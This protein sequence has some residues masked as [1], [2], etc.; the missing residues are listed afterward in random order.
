MKITL[1][2]ILFFFKFFVFFLFDLPPG[3]KL[4]MYSQVLMYAV[5]F[6]F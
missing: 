3:S 2:F 4:S 5:G 6:I 1:S